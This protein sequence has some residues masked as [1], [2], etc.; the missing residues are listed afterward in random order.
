[1]LQLFL[2][3][4]LWHYTKAYKEIYILTKNVIW[5]FFH[6]FSIKDLL[7]TLF[8]PWQKMGEQYQGGFHLSEWF[9]SKIIN[10]LMRCVGFLVR[11]LMIIIGLTCVCFAILVACGVFV[12]WTAIP[13]ILVFLF[14]S[15][16][17]LFLQTK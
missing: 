3:G 11:T 13:F 12:V 17:R 4:I 16:I 8:Y 2:S 14:I 15:S 1:M 9:S 5:F 6:L 7:K 10:I